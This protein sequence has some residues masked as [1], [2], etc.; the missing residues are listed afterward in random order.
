[1][2]PRRIDLAPT[3]RLASFERTEVVVTLDGLEAAIAERCLA[4]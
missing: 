4:L 3:Q 2:Y 1:V